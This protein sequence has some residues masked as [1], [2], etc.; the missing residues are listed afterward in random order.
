MRD[1]LLTPEEVAEQLRVT[2]NY[3]GQ[4]RFRNRGPKF[5]RHERLIR[6][7]QSDLDAWLEAGRLP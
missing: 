1:P 4:L 7:R 6:Y 3:L 2:T 5:I